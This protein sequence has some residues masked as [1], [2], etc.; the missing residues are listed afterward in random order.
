MINWETIWH[1]RWIYALNGLDPFYNPKG[2]EGGEMCATKKAIRQT[3]ENA[4]SYNVWT[5][6]GASSMSQPLLRFLWIWVPLILPQILIS[7]DSVIALKLSCRFCHNIWNSPT[8]MITF[9][10]RRPPPIMPQLLGEVPTWGKFMRTLSLGQIRTTPK[11]F[12]RGSANQPEFRI[13]QGC[14]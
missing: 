8:D 12:P 14:R 1:N 2:E 3:S 5:A 13:W 7:F 4:P 9:K 10:R 11:F 6:A